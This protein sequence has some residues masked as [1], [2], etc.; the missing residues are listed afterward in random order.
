MKVE[1]LVFS[2]EN[3]SGAK[4][5]GFGRILKKDILICFFFSIFSYLII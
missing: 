4:D 1:I 5:L 2:F 3:E